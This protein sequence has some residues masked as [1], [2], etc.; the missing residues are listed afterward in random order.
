MR[1]FIASVL[2]IMAALAAACPSPAAQRALETMLPAAFT[3][4]WTADGKVVTY[5]PENL[6]KYIDGE[7]ELYLPYGFRK[8][9]TVMYV[10]AGSGDT[11]I[12]VNIFEMGS[13]LDAF[14]IYANYRSPTLKRIEVGAE[15]FLDESQ[16]MFYQDRYFVQVES[17]GALTQEGPV[18]LACAEAVSRNLPG[19]RQRPLEVE[20][21]KVAATVPLTEK[22]YA[23]G[24]LGYGFLGKGLTAEAVLEGAL[25]KPIVILGASEETAKKT[26]ADYGKYL[27]NA[28][29]QVEVANDKGGLLLHA[30][31]PLYK[32]VVLF[33]SGRYV[34]GVVG[35][36]EPHEGD[37]LVTRLAGRLP[38]AQ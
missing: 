20:F 7:A 6:Y 16:L 15:G 10:K 22:Y 27:K 28:G 26:L 21:L 24:I 3:P 37:E 38:G 34:V 4:G 14:G 31:D 9:V 12:V 30:V 5:T 23:A 19:N 32:G 17:S 18:F 33:Q 8:A 25:V 13:P 29:A 1:G 11:G 2:C 35:L 36:G